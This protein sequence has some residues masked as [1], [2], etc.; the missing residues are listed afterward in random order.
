MSMIQQIDTTNNL[1][2]FNRC[3]CHE[4]GSFLKYCYFW[5]S[6]NLNLTKKELIY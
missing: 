5:H 2:N 1:R 6:S 3:C 4:H